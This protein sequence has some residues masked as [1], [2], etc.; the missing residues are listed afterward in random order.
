MY[1]DRHYINLKCL[2]AK[3]LLRTFE[4]LVIYQCLEIILSKKFVRIFKVD[5]MK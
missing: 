1:R 5:Q 4:V 3:Q 2:L